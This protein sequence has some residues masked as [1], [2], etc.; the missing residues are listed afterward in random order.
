MMSIWLRHRAWL[1]CLLAA[2]ATLCWASSAPL[3]SRTSPYVDAYAECGVAE[4][5][6]TD[7]GPAINACLAAHPGKHVMLRKRG[8]SNAGGGTPT[9]VDIYS[10]QT[11]TMVGNAQHL[12]CEVPSL[13]SGGCRINFDPKLTGPGIAVPPDAVG[14]QISN[15]ELNGG[16]CWSPTV[17]NTYTL[18]TRINGWGNDGILLAG[19]EARLDNVISKC[20]KRHGISAMGDSSAYDPQTHKYS[21]PDF[22]RLDRISVAGNRGYGMYFTG[23]DS[24]AGL[25]TFVDARSNQ[26]G[27]IYDFSVL[28]NTW[29]APG[30]HTNTRNPVKA[31]VTQAVSSIRVTRSIAT[32]TT[33]GRLANGLGKVGTWITI[34]GSTDA[35]FNGTCKVLTINAS[36]K[37]LTCHIDHA[38]GST[39]GGAIGTASSTLVYAAYA[40]TDD[41]SGSGR[42]WKI[43]GPYA[44]RGGSSTQVVINPYCESDEQ[45]PDFGNRTLVLGG[46]CWMLDTKG[47]HGGV[48]PGNEGVVFD[49]GNFLFQRHDDHPMFFDLR[50]G[51]TASPDQ[52]LRF[53]DKD[54]KTRWRI[55]VNAAGNLKLDNNGAL[56][57]LETVGERTVIGGAAY[58]D[59][60]GK[61]T[62][63]SGVS[64]SSLSGLTSTAVVP[65]LNAE[66]VNG[67][68][69][70]LAP[71]SF[72]ATPT[73]DAAKANTFKITLAGQ[74]TRST[75]SDATP[76]QMLG[77]I[78]C[79]DRGGGHS[80][81]W[82]SNVRGGMIV[83]A[84]ANKCSVQTFVFD[85]TEAYA[86]SSGV[87]E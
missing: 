21:Q 35:S 22:L 11:I 66:M 87:T 3:P 12:D 34:T 59:K 42:T 1:S 29:I 71:M 46:N 14:V 43:A 33:A 45:T 77:F 83:D 56:V 38:N 72:S 62:F 80:F 74:V 37:Q 85:G 64:T 7:D 86:L 82:P 24:N 63:P 75:L 9:S 31:G 25:I 49:G 26:L 51:V 4:D 48:R 68:H 55:S 65:N 28:G 84:T 15:L 52:S 6:N 44:G 32:I 19:G 70:T 81:R 67:Q 17:L 23:A 60:K 58:V 5:G 79:Q 36:S 69:L 30:M 73:F 20:F 53:L 27:G 57:P 16:N 76:G 41:G 18:P 61:G 47:D 50:S 2:S 8:S 13:W 54:G 39:A 40:A 78:I 10:S